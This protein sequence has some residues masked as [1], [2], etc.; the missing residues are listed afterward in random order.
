M[1]EQVKKLVEAE[2]LR[3]TEQLDDIIGAQKSKVKITRS[4]P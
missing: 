3:L 4:A 2:I 1:S